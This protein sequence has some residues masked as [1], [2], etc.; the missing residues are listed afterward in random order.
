MGGATRVLRPDN[1]AALRGQW[2]ISGPKTPGA[3][4]S[5]RLLAS[6]TVQ[7]PGSVIVSLPPFKSSGFPAQAGLT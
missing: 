7:K 1:G 4:R 6:R 2:V 5:L 3:G